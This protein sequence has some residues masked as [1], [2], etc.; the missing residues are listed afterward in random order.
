M[1]KGSAA[2]DLNSCTTSEVG[3]HAYSAPNAID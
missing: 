3:L 2:M 1:L